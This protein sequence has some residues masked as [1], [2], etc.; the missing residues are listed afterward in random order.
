MDTRLGF[1]SAHWA[2]LGKGALLLLN[3]LKYYGL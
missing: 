3:D 2:D 1:C